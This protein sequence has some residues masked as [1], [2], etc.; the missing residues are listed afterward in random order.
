MPLRIMNAAGTARTVADARALAN[1]AL[2][3]VTLGSFTQAPR[4]GNTGQTFYFENGLLGRGG[5]NSLGMPNGG[6]PFM[7]QELPEAA[8][9]IHDHDKLLRVSIAGDTENEIRTLAEAA[10]HAGADTVEVNLGCPN[11]WDGG[12]QKRIWSFDYELVARAIIA[13]RQGCSRRIALKLSP[14]S[15]PFQFTQLLEHLSEHHNMFEEVVCS[16]TFPNGYLYDDQR[17]R[18]AIDPAGGLGGVSG[19]FMLPIACGQVKRARE[20]LPMTISVVGAGGIKDGHSL[21]QHLRAGA[22][23]VQVGTQYY[24]YQRSEVFS[25]ILSDFVNLYPEFAATFVDQ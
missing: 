10:Q 9:I 6:L 23:A 22:D 25:A 15:D 3:E 8:R 13:A 11:V 7:Q 1:S 5:I 24:Q 20:V 14:I 18:G 4:S 2:T 12:K 21:H 16:N 19:S 17:R